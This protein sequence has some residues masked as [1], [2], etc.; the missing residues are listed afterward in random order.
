MIYP[1]SAC[2]IIGAAIGLMRTRARVSLTTQVCY[3]RTNA[4]CITEAQVCVH[5]YRGRARGEII[6]NKKNFFFFFQNTYT[7][8]ERTK[9]KTLKKRLRTA[10][11]A[12]RPDRKHMCVCVGVC[13]N[14][15]PIILEWIH[16]HV[17][18]APVSITR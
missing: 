12:R 10:A 16:V 7:D 4:L 8:V 13:I 3:L 14:T 18:I 2:I 15:R 5:R 1:G 6:R 11:E 9:N 17:H